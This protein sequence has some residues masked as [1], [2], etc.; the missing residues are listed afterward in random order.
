VPVGAHQI[1][2]ELPGY[3]AVTRTTSISR[4]GQELQLEPITLVPQAVS[5]KITTDPPGLA[6]TLNPA[7]GGEPRAGTGADDVDLEPGRYE[8][9]WSQPQLGNQSTTVEVEVGAKEMPL[10]FELPYAMVAIDCATPGAAVY[11]ADGTRLGATPFRFG[12]VKPGTYTYTLKAP[13]YVQE[14]VSY[15]A[16]EKSPLPRQ[17]SLAVAPASTPRPATVQRS[18]PKPKPKPAAAPKRQTTPAKPVERNFFDK[19]RQ[20]DNL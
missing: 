3:K 13:G 15:Q 12:P 11:S 1:V 5:V 18:A 9:T 14:N 17:I 2:V 16:L 10:N 6:W 20:Y 8:A 7:D 19:T 4:A